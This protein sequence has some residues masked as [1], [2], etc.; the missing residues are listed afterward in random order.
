ML[1]SQQLLGKCLQAG[2][3]HG[4]ASAWLF[5]KQNSA[6]GADPQESEAQAIR[7][8]QASSSEPVALLPGESFQ[9]LPPE[10]NLGLAIQ[11]RAVL[12]CCCH[13]VTSLIIVDETAEGWSFIHPLHA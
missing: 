4:S 2:D 13:W 11:E 8:Q 9:V 3:K 7:L 12:A 10:Q 5:L 6:A 1:S